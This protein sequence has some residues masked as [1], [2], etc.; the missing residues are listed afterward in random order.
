M[1]S[2]TISLVLALT[3]LGTPAL[4]AKS[5][6]KASV[7]GAPFITL[8]ALIEANEASIAANSSLIADNAVAISNNAISIGVLEDKAAQVS[9]D[10]A[11]L[12][13]RISVN[14]VDIASAMNAISTISSDITLLTTQLNTLTADIS[15]RVNILTTDVNILKSTVADL[16]TSL[17]TLRSDMQTAV[18]Q[19]DAAIEANSGEIGVLSAVVTSMDAKLTLANADILALRG[20]V[21]LAEVAIATHSDSL[22]TIDAQMQALDVRVTALEDVTNAREFTV[23]GTMGYDITLTEFRNDI[24]SL[25]YISGEYLYVRGVGSQGTKE[26]CTS[27]TNAATL[28]QYYVND[29]RYMWAQSTPSLTW[30]KTSNSWVSV[31]AVNSN[32]NYYDGDSLRIASR[33]Y[34]NTYIYNYVHPD[35]YYN[36]S[37]EIYVNGWEYDGN[38]SITYRVASTRA[39]ACGF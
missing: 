11:N 27:N 21:D 35:Y 8:N 15:S 32:S 37:Q 30:Q 6:N 28:L 24:A 12:E 34:S 7:N 25:N 16:S 22:L 3:L 13:T 4:A 19:L 17:T 39:E 2:S 10:L 23:H 31:N 26:F 33:D 38:N 1:L 36:P 14:E 9:T 18:A 5:N 20:R 29:I